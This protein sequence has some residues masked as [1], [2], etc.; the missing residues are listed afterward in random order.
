MT[1][2]RPGEPE[3]ELRVTAWVDAP[4]HDNVR[5]Q[6][7]RHWASP[8]PARPGWVAATVCA[9][10]VAPTKA[11]MFTWAVHAPVDGHVRAQG[12]ATT[13][14]RARHLADIAIGHQIALAVAAGHWDADDR[15]T[16]E[17]WRDTDVAFRGRVTGG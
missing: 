3:F 14:D 7:K 16:G 1:A 5:R 17:R 8:P 13:A 11:I 15:P 9:I 10:E 2:P 6:W 12:E 4:A